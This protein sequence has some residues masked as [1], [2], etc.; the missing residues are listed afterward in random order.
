MTASKNKTTPQMALHS[1]SGSPRDK[2]L[3]RPR[4]LN[5]S[6]MG[7]KAT[8]YQRP[9][10]AST[11]PSATTN[12]EQTH[13]RPLPVQ[14]H[15]HSSTIEEHTYSSSTESIHCHTTLPHVSHSASRT[16]LA[17]TTYSESRTT[18]ALTKPGGGAGR[19]HA[20]TACHPPSSRTF[21]HSV[22]RPDVAGRAGTHIFTNRGTR[23]SHRARSL[24]VSRQRGGSIGG[25][26]RAAASSLL[27]LGHAREDRLPQRLGTLGARLTPALGT[28]RAG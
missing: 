10:R 3:S 15:T 18:L 7:D 6:E 4:L 9:L 23:T 19:R 22:G 1:E 24:P 8:D 21:A 16:T 14:A 11:C 28:R 2:M 20:A 26:G 27:L 13:F 5:R 17:L 25:G 12:T